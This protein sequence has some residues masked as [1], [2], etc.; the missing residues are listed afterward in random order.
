MLLFLT[1]FP[2]T[3][4]PPSVVW[5]QPSYS[6][7]VQVTCASSDLLSDMS[8]AFSQDNADAAAVNENEV[9]STTDPAET[10]A[11]LAESLPSSVAASLANGLS[12]WLCVSF[13]P[14]DPRPNEPL[15]QGQNGTVPE[16]APSQEAPCPPTAASVLV[17]HDAP[18]SQPEETLDP[19]DLYLSSVS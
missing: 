9:T 8:L 11:S 19:Q 5:R 1:A 18:A 10:S 6:L 13:R 3:R 17:P 7:Q 12:P 4:S 2:P 16:A 14:D 15:F